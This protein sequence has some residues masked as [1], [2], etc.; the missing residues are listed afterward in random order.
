MHIFV[1]LSVQIYVHVCFNMYIYRLQEYI[2]NIAD[3]RTIRQ[4]NGR[5]Y[6]EQVCVCECVY[7]RESVCVLVRV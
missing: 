5:L 1:R 7:E 4:P 3:S 2:P 6:L